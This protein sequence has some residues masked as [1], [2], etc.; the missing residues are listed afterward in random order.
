[1]VLF[2]RGNSGR[3]VGSILDVR[4]RISFTD[5]VQA[6]SVWFHSCRRN[7]TY[8]VWKLLDWQLDAIYDFFR[9][10]PDHTDPFLDILPDC[11]SPDIA[12]REPSPLWRLKFPFFCDVDNLCRPDDWDAM[13]LYNIYRDPWERSLP[14][15]KPERCVR[16]TFD[17]PEAAMMV[18]QVMAALDS[19]PKY[20]A[21][22]RGPLPALDKPYEELTQ[23]ERNARTDA[24]MD[25]RIKRRRG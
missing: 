9:N 24:A 13:A 23:E 14:D 11:D 18:S 12:M 22:A 2:D 10:G 20:N 4:V 3:Q 15:K 7:W 6:N 25:F 8:R 21:L 5:G 16:N 17:Y 1:M 19:T